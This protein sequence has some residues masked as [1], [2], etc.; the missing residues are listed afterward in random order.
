MPGWF[1]PLCEGM[2][3]VLS[4]FDIL[5]ATNEITPNSRVFEIHPTVAGVPVM[6]STPLASAVINY[7][8]SAGN[9]F[10]G[11][12]ISSFG[13]TVSPGDVLAIV[14]PGQADAPG[15]WAGRAYT[16]LYADGQYYTTVYTDPPDYSIPSTEYSPF[17]EYDLGFRTY[18]DDG[19]IPI[20]APPALLLVGIGAICAVIRR[21]R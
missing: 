11:A 15:W 13:I 17:P 2:P 7:G 9:H 20:P 4:R 1:P 14:E 6:G 3:G 12:D 8:T 10:Y 21:P 18:V 5:I 19:T 16:G